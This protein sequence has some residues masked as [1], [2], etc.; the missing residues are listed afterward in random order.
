M[1]DP[2]TIPPVPWPSVIETVQRRRIA[3]IQERK[4]EECTMEEWDRESESSREFINFGNGY[5][6]ARGMKR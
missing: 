4:W 2:V 3:R 5:T 6:F 1:S